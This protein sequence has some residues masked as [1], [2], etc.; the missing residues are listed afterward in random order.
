MDFWLECLRLFFGGSDIGYIR[1]FE[2]SGV[3]EE[4]GGSGCDNE[5]GD[6]VS[7]VLTVLSTVVSALTMV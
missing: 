5:I 4:L 1:T 3:R 2:V 6:T 7:S